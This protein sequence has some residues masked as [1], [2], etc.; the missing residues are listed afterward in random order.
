MHSAEDDR[1]IDPLT[2]C[3]ANGIPCH[4]VTSLESAVGL[5]AVAALQPDLAVHA[6][7]GIVRAP[8]LAIPRLGTLNAHM[9]VLPYYRGVHVAE[10]AR[11][12]GDPVGCTVHLLDPGIHTGP[13]V[14]VRLV[15]TSGATSIEA[16][17]RLVDA[18][19]IALLGR[20]IQFV[21]RSR[22]LPPLRMQRAE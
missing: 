12:N 19:Q 18:A 22:S 3:L 15:D 5:A 11:F 9:G 7:A 4:E 13:I 21:L 1:P 10:W 14:C 8:V 2:Y 17:R 16:L 6:G 20:V